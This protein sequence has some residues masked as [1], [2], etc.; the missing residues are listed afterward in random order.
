VT[1][2]VILNPALRGNFFTFSLSTVTNRTYYIQSKTNLTDP[3]W[4]IL[5]TLPGN[6][7]L[8]TITVPL[9]PDRQRFFRFLV[10]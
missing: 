10:Q 1:N 5:E 6:G 2:P 9:G 7:N 3:T 4:Q 8:Q